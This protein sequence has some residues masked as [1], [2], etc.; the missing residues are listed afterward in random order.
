MLKLK[1]FVD[2]LRESVAKETLLRRY[3]VNVQFFELTYVLF[4]L[5]VIIAQFR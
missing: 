2:E 3:F 1:C 5:F 4:R